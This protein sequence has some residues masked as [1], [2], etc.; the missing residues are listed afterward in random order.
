MI[1]LDHVAIATSEPEKLK[2]VFMLLGLEDHGVEPVSTQG[3][4]T[5]FLKPPAQDTTSSLAKDTDARPSIELLEP[6]DPNG[7]IE[8]F[9][10]KRGPGLHHISFLVSDLNAVM[11]ALSENKIRLV[12][13]QPKPGAHKTQVNFIHPDSTGGVLIEIAQRVDTG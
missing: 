3:I 8:K 10:K 4:K 9:I 2:K 12:Y 13:D 11:R 5:H 1:V 7:V 6:T